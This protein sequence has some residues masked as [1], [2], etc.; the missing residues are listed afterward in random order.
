MKDFFRLFLIVLFTGISVHGLAQSKKPLTHDVYD[1]WK[2]LGERIISNNGKYVGY[3]INPQVGDGVLYVKALVS[4]KIWEIPRGYDAKFLNSSNF[5][6]CKV[7]PFYE[8]TR[9]ARIKKKTGDDF[10]ADS[11]VV[12]DLLHDSLLY[13]PSV[14]SYK[15]PE[16]EGDWLAYL[17]NVPKPDAVGSSSDSLKHLSKRLLSIADSVLKAAIDSS[18]GELT[19]KELL[20]ALQKAEK[21]IK[22]LSDVVSE[23]NNAPPAEPAKDAKKHTQTLV[24]IRLNDNAEWR[25]PHV[26]D[27][28]FDEHGA[29]LLLK[30]L[31]PK[32]DSTGKSQIILASL[33]APRFDT[34]MQGFNSASGF[35]FDED[36]KQVAF[37]AERD[38]SVKAL[39]K[40]F[41]L[42]YY[43]EGT[44]SAVLYAD[45]NSIGM[46][47]GWGVS[48][49]GN[50][51]FSKNGKHLYFGTAPVQPA[52]DTTLVDFEL[53]R[54]DIW[55]YNDDYLQPYQLKQ[56][57]REE[58]RS[59]PAVISSGN[60]FLV[61]LGN[62]D[63]EYIT[64]VDEGN[65]DWVL[66]TSTR[67]NRIASQWEGRTKQSA[68]IISCFN[69]KA[70]PV[71]ENAPANFYPSP[72]GKYVYWYDYEKQ[73]YFTYDVA[74]RKIRNVSNKI[75]VPLYN[76][77]Y[78]MPDL[79]DPV[80]NIGWSEN[81]ASFFV[82]DMFDV[83]KLDP[84]AA[85]SPVNL[86]NGYGRTS[87]IQFNYLKTD[88]D[89]RFFS[90]GEVIL[91]KGFNKKNKQSGLYFQDVDSTTAPHTACI[92]PY[93]LP[94]VWKAKDTGVYIIQRTDIS[95]SELYLSEN[96]EKWEQLTHIADQQKPYNWLTVSLEKWKM[97]DGNM[98]EGLLY[99]PENFDPKKKYP[100]IFYFYERDADGLYNYRAPAPSASIIN[101]PWF[102]SNGYLV[103]DPNIYYKTGYPGE[104]AYNSVVSA[105]KHFSKMPW[106]DSTRMGIQG[107]S[108]GGYEVAYLV[109]RTN[110][111]RAAGAGAP[112][113]NMTSAYGGIRWGTGLNRQFQYEKTQSRIGATLWQNREAYIRNSPLFFADK[114][115]TPL[116]IMH[117]DNDGAVPWYQGIELFTAMKR[118]HKKVWLLQYNGEDH[119]LMERRNRKDLSVRLGQF[120]DYYLKG[121]KPASW[122]IHGLPATQKGKYW[123]IDSY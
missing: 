85:L 108:W 82:R 90:P 119:N 35:C 2:S 111:F 27:Y 105:A 38:S 61:Q 24:I 122:I 68:Y 62:P 69:G 93:G 60:S 91:L 79:P 9:N 104:S 37:L 120:F 88:K 30:Q 95:S 121:S 7:K 75:K 53:A 66:G 43:R 6:V 15:V 21:E 117:N 29:H 20:K 97:F 98:S 107:Q 57:N 48:E 33:H 51:S 1:G 11:L 10:P 92:G 13:I 14:K 46:P 22:K 89:K 58:K 55:H 103:F 100:I 102:V 110:I 72:S 106:V 71:I 44:D 18:K 74:E 39:Q 12:L 78:D 83:W 49:F 76:T 45:R 81:D 41:K 28:L 52:E 77:E 101:I 40:F 86:T 32:D 116:L 34:I 19:E 99:K 65:A 118:L 47:L 16:K 50:L 25:F 42:W 67:N 64:L 31:I 114:I 109:T 8:Q 80:G 17:T 70:N 113:S 112:V 94:S 123:G 59:Y 115:K 73:H 56:L 63:I 26:E 84:K 36:G 87:Q 54:L 4:E 5:L 3:S 96:F 23:E